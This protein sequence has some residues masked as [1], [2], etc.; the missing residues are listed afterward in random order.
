MIFPCSGATLQPLVAPRLS[1]WNL[2][3]NRE[4]TTTM[5][6][7]PTLSPDLPLPPDTTEK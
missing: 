4:F 1:R 6:F 2:S 5:G 3:T 7:Y